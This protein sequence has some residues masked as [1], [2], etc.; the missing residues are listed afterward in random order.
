MWAVRWFGP[1]VQSL[2]CLCLCRLQ[3]CIHC[4]Q[5]PFG[6]VRVAR[7]VSYYVKPQ[8]DAGH[9]QASR[10]YSLAM[11]MQLAGRQHQLS[12]CTPTPTGQPHSAVS[13]ATHTRNMPAHQIQVRPCSPGFCQPCMHATSRSTVTANGQ[14]TDIQSSSPS[15]CTPAQ[16]GSVSIPCK[17]GNKVAQLPAPI[18]NCW[19]QTGRCVYVI[20]L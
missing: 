15:T 2:V 13:L 17:P 16:P 5:V 10:H 12:F 1:V 9:R 3:S 7:V 11:L 6:I 18:K 14:G 19:L 4:Q 8:S 20:L